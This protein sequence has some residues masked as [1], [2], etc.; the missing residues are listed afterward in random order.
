VVA[1]CAS[2]S[3]AL[4]LLV[5]AGQVVLVAFKIL[6][7]WWLQIVLAVVKLYCKV[8]YCAS[9]SHALMLLVFTDCASCIQVLMLLVVAGCASCS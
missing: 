5:V 2:Y 1:G 4:L 9:C 7:Y 8:A 6:C 3:Q